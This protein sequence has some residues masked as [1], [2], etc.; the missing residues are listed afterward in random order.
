[1]RKLM[2][3]AAG[4]ILAVGALSLGPQQAYAVRPSPE[5]GPTRQ[6]ICGFRG[7]PYC[8]VVLFEGT[9]CEKQQ[10]DKETG[11]TCSPA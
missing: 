10:Y 5:C 7:C 4:V 2:R 8:P 9:V 11:R 3:V 1:M 6:W